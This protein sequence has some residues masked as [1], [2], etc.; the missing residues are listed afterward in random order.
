MDKTRSKWNSDTHESRVEKLYGTGIEG[1]H[2]YHDGYLNFG[3]WDP[4]NIPYKEAAENM[5]LLLAKKLGLNTSSKLLDVGCGMG[6]QDI[7][8]TQNFN[9][10]SI[11]A[12]DVTWKHIERGRERA[13]RSEIGENKLRF[14]HGT[15]VSLPFDN[16]TFTHILSIEAP[17]HFDTREDFFREAYRA[18]KPGGVLAIS[19]Y[20]L[21]R[22][23]KNFLEK[24]MVEFAGRVWCAPKENIYGN[25]VFRNKLENIG[26]TGISIDNVGE[27]VIPGYYF[28]GKRAE[29]R[30]EAKKVRG[31]KGM[32]GGDI[33]DFAIYTAWKRGLCEYIILRAEKPK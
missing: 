28:E 20:S 30:K 8:L 2:E 19:D 17:P 12:M 15:A 18:L 29:A 26:F 6:T 4:P 25:D 3:F 1:F 9:P 10:L 16:E 11:D 27:L 32:I 13:R 21:T 23:P 14:H 24:F 5:V 22:P 33:L 7:F 31:I